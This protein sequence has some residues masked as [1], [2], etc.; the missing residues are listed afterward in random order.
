MKHDRYPTYI[1]KGNLE[2]AGL[3]NNREFQ[4]A[5][6]ATAMGTY[7]HIK[8]KNHLHI[9]L[10]RT[11]CNGLSKQAF[12]KEHLAPFQIL[13]TSYPAMKEPPGEYSPI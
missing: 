11:F 1:R 2:N 5:T 9:F 8:L 6:T 12:S 4:K 13:F 7:G 10:I 3:F